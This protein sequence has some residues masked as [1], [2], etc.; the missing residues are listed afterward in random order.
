MTDLARMLMLGQDESRKPPLVRA[1]EVQCERLKA[2]EAV[3][4]AMDEGANRVGLQVRNALRR[5]PEKRP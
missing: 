5:A 3:L 2:E 4:T 1:A